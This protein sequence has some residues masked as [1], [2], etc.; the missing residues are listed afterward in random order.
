MAQQPSPSTDEPLRALAER[1]AHKYIILDGH[2][3]LPYRLR[4]RNFKF[5]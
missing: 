5:G 4:V 1:L 2:V 3:D